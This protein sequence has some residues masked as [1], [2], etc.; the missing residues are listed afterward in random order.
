MF[1]LPLVHLFNKE[2]EEGGVLCEL[3]V[4]QIVEPA[5]T[6]HS[7]TVVVVHLSVLVVRLVSKEFG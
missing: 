7:V 4:K 2:A 6:R 5:R 1:T 3:L